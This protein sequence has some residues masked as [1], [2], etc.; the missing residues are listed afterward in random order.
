MSVKVLI[1]TLLRDLTANAAVVEVEA[2]DIRQMITVLD[3]TFPGFKFRLCNDQ[4][5]IRPYLNV[6]LNDEDIRFAAGEDTKLNDGDEVLI[7][8]AVG[9]G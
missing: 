3:N 8:A 4:D 7:V 6:V 9:G 1:P 2:A 5:K